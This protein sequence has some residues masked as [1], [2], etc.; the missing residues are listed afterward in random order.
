MSPSIYV[1]IH[2]T[3]AEGYINGTILVVPR[4]P[5]LTV[6]EKRFRS[7]SSLPRVRPFLEKIPLLKRVPDLLKEICRLLQR[8][9]L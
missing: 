4:L 5:S 9:D 3:L 6:A 8:V 7:A 2:N 1:D